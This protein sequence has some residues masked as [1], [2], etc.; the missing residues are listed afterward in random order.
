MFVLVFSS[1][2]VIFHSAFSLFVSVF[3]TALVAV[4]V[5]YD[6]EWLNVKKTSHGG[7][8]K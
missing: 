1:F 4:I 7:Q 5:E 2:P 8:P 3:S 6:V